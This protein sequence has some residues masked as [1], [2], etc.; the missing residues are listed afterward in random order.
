MEPVGEMPEDLVGERN[1]CP[2][3]VNELSMLTLLDS[4]SMVSTIN[5]SY[6]SE[7]LPDQPISSLD[8]L[9]NV[10]GASGSVIPYRGYV[11]LGINLPGL[12][13]SKF[14]FLVVEETDYNSRIPVL[15]ETNVLHNTLEELVNVYGVGFAQKAKLPSAMTC[16]FSV[17]QTARKYLERSCITSK[18]HMVEAVHLTPGQGRRV[19]GRI[20]VDTPLPMPAALVSGIGEYRV[21]AWRWHPLQCALINRHNSSSLMC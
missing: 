20:K 2:V 8:D 10:S 21:V 6:W 5:H 7:N 15:I 12:K 9:L 11:E 17:V 19:A 14:P 16:A 4:G 13:V 18:V 3:L 1:E